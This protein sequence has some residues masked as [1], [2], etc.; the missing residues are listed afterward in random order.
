[1]KQTVFLFFFSLGIL[2]AQAPDY[3]PLVSGSTWVYRSLNGSSPLTIKI[4]PPAEFKGQVYSRLEGYANH[5]LFVRRT[6]AGNFMYWDAQAQKD[7]AF[8]TFRGPDFDSVVTNCRQTGQPEPREAVY[9]GPVGYSDTARVIRYTPGICA[10]TGLTS[11]TF[12]PYL[13]MV[14]RTETSFIGER[15]LD[16]VYAQIGGF[17]YINENGVTFSIALTALPDA[18]GARLVLHNRKDE[19][20]KLTF[21]STQLYDYSVRNSAGTVVYTWSADK[22]FAQQITE[23][24]VRGEEVWSDVLPAAKFPPGIY[25][26]EGKLVNTDGKKFS[27]VASVNLP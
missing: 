18:I 12:V 20:I 21:T 14:K 13:G 7:V 11:E 2:M 5:P 1:M 25:T 22:L 24:T 3:F 8:L 16:L 10:D 4:G 19:P 15:S 9:R 23:L 26:V 6:E 27:A 17:T